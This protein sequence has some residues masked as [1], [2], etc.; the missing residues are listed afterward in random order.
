M[1]SK[2]HE[3]KDMNSKWMQIHVWGKK[4]G[5]LHKRAHFC[6]LE[7]RHVT[8]VSPHPPT[9]MEI[10]GEGPKPGFKWMKVKMGPL[11]FNIQHFIYP[12]H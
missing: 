3:F 1:N 9:P 2:T 12:F 8:G 6:P 7:L 11:R 5:F 4:G 10:E